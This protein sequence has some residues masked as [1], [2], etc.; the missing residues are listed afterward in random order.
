M[1]PGVKNVF[2]RSA[3]CCARTWATS[4]HRFWVT[5]SFLLQKGWSPG[6]QCVTKCDHS[7][8]KPSELAYRKGDMLTI[9]E[10]GVGK[11]VYRAQ[12]NKTGEQGLISA[13]NVRE[14]EAIRVDPSL[15]LMPWFHGKISGPEAVNKLQPIED[16]LFLVRESIRHPGDYVLCVIV[17]QEVI[18]YRVIYKDNKLTIDNSKFF[19]NLIDMI[20]FYTKNQGALATTLQKP[21]EKAGAKSAEVELSKAGWL[22]DIDKL[23]LGER[24]GEGEFGAV[25]MGHYMGQRVAVKDIKCDVTAQAFLEETAVMTKLQHRNLVRLHGVILHNGLHIVTEFMDKGNLVNFLRTRGRSV[26][27]TGQLLRFALDV[28]A[29]MEYLESKKLVH[30]DLAARNILVSSDNV[31]KISDFGLA[32]TNPKTS[33]N[34]KLPVKWTAP[35]ALKKEKFST[36]SDVWSYGVLLWETFSYGRQPYPKMSLKEVKEKVEQGY[37]MEAPE[38][39]PTR[40]YALMRTC[41]EMDPGKRPSFHKLR[42]KLEREL[43]CYS[44]VTRS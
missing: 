13:S 17:G 44:T 26:I 3:L 35:E 29:G 12:H 7:K 30:R 38:N 2:R 18:H 9:I 27:D 40:I 37:R 5:D 15:S 19:Y 34:V 42:E 10:A 20:E 24:I 11:G 1:P 33:D 39:C 8:P 41:W 43:S 28:C 23:A 31:A 4:V 14:R 6:T 32:Q 16:G 22:L 21:K 36:R 25:Y